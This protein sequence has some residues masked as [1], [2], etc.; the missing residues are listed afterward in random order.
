MWS[1][2]I[3]L[4]SARLTAELKL[5]KLWLEKYQTLCGVEVDKARF[6][7]LRIK[8]IWF[9]PIYVYVRKLLKT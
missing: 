4:Q 7:P 1:P 6:S 2:F 8:C 9:A 3:N 5:Y